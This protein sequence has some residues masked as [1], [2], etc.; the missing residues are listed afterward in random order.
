[1]KKHRI[2]TVVL[3]V[4]IGRFISDSFICGWVCYGLHEIACLLY[5]EYKNEKSC[6]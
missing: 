4:L 6:H 2:L 5:E 1:M 3:I